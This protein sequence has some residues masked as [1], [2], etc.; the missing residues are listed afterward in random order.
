MFKYAVDLRSMSQG[1]GVFTFE[2]VRYE[3]VPSAIAD[4]I[5][6]DSEK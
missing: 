1:R 3:Q 2:F 5:I 4:K 6:A